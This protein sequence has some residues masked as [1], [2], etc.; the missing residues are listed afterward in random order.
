MVLN[1]KKS[2]KLAPLQNQAQKGRFSTKITHQKTQSKGYISKQK[3]LNI[4]YLQKCTSDL[5][6]MW[7]TSAATPG[8]P[9]I[10]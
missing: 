3:K 2:V 1:N 8:V 9:A 10:S 7:L 6:L 5:E 4:A